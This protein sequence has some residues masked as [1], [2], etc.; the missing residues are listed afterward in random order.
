MIPAHGATMSMYPWRGSHATNARKGMGMQASSMDA[1]TD[2]PEWLQPWL[3]G[4]FVVVALTALAGLLLAADKISAA[5]IWYAN[6]ILL[7]VMLR[8]PWRHWTA[9]VVAGVIGIV[10]ARLLVEQSAVLAIGLALCSALEVVLAAWAIRRHTG[11]EDLDP[12]RLLR[13]TRIGV[14]WSVLAPIA[15]GV[16]AA[17]L[18]WYAKSAPPWEEFATWYAAHA[19]GMIIVTP[20][21]LVAQRRVFARMLAPGRARSTLLA[22]G[23]L[24]AVSLAVFLVDHTQLLFVIFPPLL[25]VVFRLGFA[26][27]AVGVVMVSMTGVIATVSGHGPFVLEE[28]STQE[29]V[30]ALQ[31][32]VAVA[33]LMA[34]PISVAL[35]DRRS[36]RRTLQE[37]E[38]R[39][40]TLADYSSDIIVRA[41]QDGTRL[42]VSPSVSDV[43]GW[44]P[45]E[46]LGPARRDLVH[47]EDRAI[48]DE[49]L[50]AMRSGAVTSTLTY[51]YRHKNGHYVWVESITRRVPGAEPSRPAEIVRVIR[52]ISTRKHTE[53]ALLDSEHALRAVSDS[54]PALVARLDRDGRYTFANAHHRVV[55]GVEPASLLG[56]SVRETIGEELYA[57]LGPF[58]SQV[59]AGDAVQFEAE[60]KTQ[61]VPLY[62]HVSC[63]PDRD[64][65]GEVIG[66]Y[67]MVMD[68]T[69]RKWAEL[70]QAESESRLRTITDNLPVLISFVDANGIV[71]FC[72]AT[73]EDWLDKGTEQLL[74]RPLRE[75]LGEATYTAQLAQFRAALAGER[76]EFEFDIAGPDGVRN[77]RAIYVPQTRPDGRV[78]GVYMLT[79]DMTSIKRVEEE[80]HRLARF[81]SL[82]ALANRRQFDEYLPRAIEKAREAGHPLALLFIDVDHFKA[83]ND[84]LGHAG[85]DEVLQE[86]AWR[87]HASVREGDFVARLAGDEFVILL[88]DVPSAS[89]AEVVAT[90]VV[91]TVRE[92]F[93]LVAGIRQ[94]TTSVGAAFVPGGKLDAAEMMHLADQALYE[95]KAAGRDTARLA[96]HDPGR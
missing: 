44:T 31:F 26:G 12:E 74:G 50:A 93:E 46:L 59:L 54:L 66:F 40:R 68:I 63:V 30:L 15:S 29:R 32:F 25:Y 61:G 45:E 65:S 34:F 75:A 23:L 48:F 58:L 22:F 36:L 69:A 14:L 77:A 70:Q 81:D 2:P 47:P 37:S 5:P 79:L 92:P 16:F 33:S 73:Y 28:L 82:T 91:A 19:L 86:F 88:E 13:F 76:V 39:Y 17:L 27:A 87:L 83:I 35:A 20:L 94:V 9:I 52:D 72:N 8:V 1:R 80:L 43:L 38:R 11:D 24:A 56:K 95:A 55:F 60:R 67:A 90:K 71:R 3:A 51:R 4:L 21:V 18:F 96:V 42:Y 84:T 41:L 10:A 78:E 49:E 85:G 89:E 7:G 62:F 6:G 53:N 57:Q 64:S